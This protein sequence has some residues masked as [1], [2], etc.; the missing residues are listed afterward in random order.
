MFGCHCN[1]ITTYT[2]IVADSNMFIIIISFKRLFYTLIYIIFVLLATL[3]FPNDSL[4]TAPQVAG[5]S[6][7]ILHRSGGG[8][9]P[10]Y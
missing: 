10:A 6:E 5:H 1:C 4:C 8:L 9:V 7:R 2:Q 3:L